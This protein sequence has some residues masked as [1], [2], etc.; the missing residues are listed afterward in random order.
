LGNRP[1]HPALINRPTV[2]KNTGH[3]GNYGVL[4][5]HL[6]PGTKSVPAGRK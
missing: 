5:K 6:A 3:S 1:V 2:V 4:P